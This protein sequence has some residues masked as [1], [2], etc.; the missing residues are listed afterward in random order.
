MSVCIFIKVG[1]VI[2]DETT[3]SDEARPYSFVPPLNKR[4]RT[5]IIEVFRSRGCG[6][7]CSGHTRVLHLRRTM[8]FDVD[9]VY[10]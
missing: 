4:G 7:T 9:E 2:R 3:N 10:S 8:L 5:A 1:F 6:V